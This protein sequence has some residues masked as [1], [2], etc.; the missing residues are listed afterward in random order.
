MRVKNYTN[1]EISH[2]LFQSVISCHTADSV[3]LRNIISRAARLGKV[4]R[5]ETLTKGQLNEIYLE[6]AIYHPWISYCFKPTA[7]T[8]WNC[9]RREGR[10]AILGV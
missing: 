10:E 3:P 8:L 1:Y 5:G 7:D 9:G 2:L 6:I 4:L